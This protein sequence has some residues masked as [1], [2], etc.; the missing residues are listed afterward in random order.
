VYDTSDRHSTRDGG[1]RVTYPKEHHGCKSH[2]NILPAFSA[3]VNRNVVDATTN[4]NSSLPITTVVLGQLVSFDR[5]PSL[6]LTHV[7]LRLLVTSQSQHPR[8]LYG[9][10]SG[11]LATVGSFTSNRPRDTKYDRKSRGER[12][13]PRID[14]GVRIM[15]NF[16]I[17]SQH[18]DVVQHSRSGHDITALFYLICA[19][20]SGLLICIST[21]PIRTLAKPTPLYMSFANRLLN[22]ITTLL[23]KF[24]VLDQRVCDLARQTRTTRLY[25]LVLLRRPRGS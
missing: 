16:S 3:R 14:S 5:G 12:I 7:T 6:W 21:A 10:N 2:Q 4:T 22:S 9:S 23:V 24:K 8:A 20:I 11:C 18:F 13:I 25:L 17:R 15:A 19:T 1:R